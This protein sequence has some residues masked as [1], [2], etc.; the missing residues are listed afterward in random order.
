LADRSWVTDNLNL[1]AF[2]AGDVTISANGQN[3]YSAVANEVQ[4]VFIVI[5]TTAFNH[6]EPVRWPLFTPNLEDGNAELNLL[7]A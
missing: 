5:E 7:A 1:S 3:T 6:I 2:S 4:E